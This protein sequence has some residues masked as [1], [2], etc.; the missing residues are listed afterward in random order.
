[1]KTRN[2][3][4]PEFYR[5]LEV[6]ADAYLVQ[7]GLNEDF[8]K[9]G[10]SVSKFLSDI[11]RLEDFKEYVKDFIEDKNTDST[12]HLVCPELSDD[13]QANDNYEFADDSAEYADLFQQ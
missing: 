1:M 12:S 11:D 8:I 7:N 10:L 3:T 9:S 6:S 5:L 13:F 4:K 2:L